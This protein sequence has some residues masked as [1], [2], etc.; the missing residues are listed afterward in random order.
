M[1]TPPPFC[2]HYTPAREDYASRLADLWAQLRQAAANGDT[3]ARAFLAMFGPF[4]AHRL[5]SLAS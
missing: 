5:R 3:E 4:A 1:S 2:Q